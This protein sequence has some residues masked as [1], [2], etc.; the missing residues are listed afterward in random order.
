LTKARRQGR[1]D[2]EARVEIAGLSFKN[3]LIAASGTFGYGV[4]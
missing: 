1:Q 4:E 3:P 2:D